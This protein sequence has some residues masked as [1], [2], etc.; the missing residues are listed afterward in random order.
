MSDN[1]DAGMPTPLSHLKV[2]DLALDVPGA[3]CGR[4]FAIWGARVDAFEPAGGSPLSRKEPLLS[5]ERGDVISLLWENLAQAKRL[6]SSTHD[7]QA[8]LAGA[9]VVIMDED[10]SG[11]TPHEAMALNPLAVVL[12]VTPFGTSGPYADYRSSELL[13]QALSGFMSLN[14]LPDRPPLKAA[15]YLAS[16]ATGVSA[17]V[18][19]LAALRERR[20]SGLGQLIEVSSL[21]A[22]TSLVPLLRTEFSGAD[23]VRQNGPTSGSV[24]YECADGF[25]ALNPV[26]GRNWDDL[27][28]ALEVAPSEVPPELQGEQRSPELIRHFLEA[29]LRQLPARKVFHAFNELRISCGLAQGPL[30]LLQDPQLAER[31]Y[32]TEVDHQTLGKVRRPGPPFRL[33]SSPP[34][35]TRPQEP[36]ASSSLDP[37]LSGDSGPGPLAGLRIIDL[38]QAWLGPYA[39][40]LLAD[41]GA[42]VIKIE[43]LQRPDSWRGAGTARR[44]PVGGPSA[45]HWTTRPANPLAHPLNT[46]G[47]FNAVNR[48]KLS[49]NLDLTTP[50]G[51]EALKGLLRDAHV[52]MENFTP[53]VMPN[54]GMSF[55]ALASERPGLVMASFSGYGASGPYRN[56]RA[57]GATTDATCGWAYL[58]GYTDG[59]PTMMGIMEADPLSGLHM[60]ASVLVGLEARD[61]TGMAQ[62]L[63]GSML[64]IGASYISEEIMLASITGSNPRRHGNRSRQHAPHGVFRCAGNDEWIAIAVEDDEQWA[65]LARASAAEGCGLDEPRFSTAHGRLEHADA[66]EARIEEWTCRLNSNELSR[67]LQALGVAA[68]PVL[69]FSAVLED[70]HFAERGWFIRTG[71]PD[72]GTHRYNG[73]PWLF[74]RTP[75]SVR[76]RPPLQG[77]HSVELLSS[78]LGYDGAVIKD[79]IERRIT[80][81]MLT[82]SAEGPEVAG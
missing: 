77:E 4:Q 78:L 18:G 49:L 12:H 55:E 40:M 59:P 39:A 25:I 11:L 6:H 13:L 80:G 8:A 72:M 44:G 36:G 16:Y 14:G 9:D 22:V 24:M 68:A 32:F 82:R 37:L 79:M 56:Y 71:H 45:A 20:R 19:A 74:S 62:H 34:A 21:E 65:A 1:A 17:F 75:C 10:W 52:L 42:D 46:S 53:R 47:S 69:P 2:V 64:E 5:T 76:R 38:T 31:S 29:R 61:E 60:A 66:L 48:N 28:L 23:A 33:S 35:A 41:L 51:K 81:S 73:F 70:R 3:Y 54:F 26:A 15:G 57:N 67:K 27:L 43:S 63:E 30:D 58:T 50:E 7:I